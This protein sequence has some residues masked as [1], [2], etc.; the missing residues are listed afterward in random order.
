MYSIP[1]DSWPSINENDIR[2]NV[3]RVEEL[4]KRVTAI[5]ELLRKAMCKEP[6]QRLTIKTIIEENIAVH[7]DTKEKAIK[8][9]TLCNQLGIYWEHN[10]E[11]ETFYQ[12][13]KELTCYSIDADK[14]LQFSTKSIYEDERFN[15]TDAPYK[16]ISFEELDLYGVEKDNTT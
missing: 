4:E 6:E 16:I 1:D 13:F 2:S 9:I 8:F 5:E 3:D 14:H 12:Y 11:P 15:G 7:C 10:N